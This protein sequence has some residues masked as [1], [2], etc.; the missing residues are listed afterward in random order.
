MAMDNRS[1]DL[2][3][4]AQSGSTGAMLQLGRDLLV[5]A[6]GRQDVAA[7]LDWLGRAGRAG[8]ASAVELLATATA[9]GVAQPPDW[10]AA[11]NLLLEAAE[12]GS[13]R[14]QGQL[15]V[16]SGAPTEPSWRGLRDAID[17]SGWACVPEREKLC[18]AP[19]VRLAKAFA[20]PAICDW[21]VSRAKGR[22]REG[23]MYDPS[24]K[25]EQVDPHRTC[26]DY[27]FDILNADLIVQLVR[28]R[29]AAATGLPTVAMEPPRIFH[30]A[31]GQ[32]I[33][34]HY[35]RVSDGYD[36]YGATEYRGDR[37]VTFLLYLNDGYEGGELSFPKADFACKGAKGD[38]V[39]F[40]HIGPDAKPDPLSLHAGLEIRSGEKW[41]MSQWIHDRPFGAAA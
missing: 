33:K 14:A 39:Y 29:I 2:E 13:M 34:A 18:D 25:L 11:L 3:R 35:D 27:Q 37:I 19:R 22:L 10:P 28:E 4:S 9:V 16:L 17:L 24:T 31:V 40:A 20:S 5:G 6:N 38:G 21:I 32:Q 41:V 7:A 12:R 15:K 30:Y 8:E 36:A 1:L 23:L 26:S